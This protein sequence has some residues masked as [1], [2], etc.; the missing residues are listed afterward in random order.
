MWRAGKRLLDGGGERG[1]TWHSVMFTKI[2]TLLHTVCSAS[3]YSF[4]INTLHAGRVWSILKKQLRHQILSSDYKMQPLGKTKLHSC[5][6]FVSRRVFVAPNINI[7]QMWIT[8]WF[9]LLKINQKVKRFL[10]RLLI[11]SVNQLYNVYLPYLLPKKW[12]TVTS[13][14]KI[15]VAVTLPNALAVQERKLQL[16]GSLSLKS[17]MIL[18]LLILFF[19][20]EQ[21]M[22]VQRGSRCIALFF[23]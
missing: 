6:F 10:N 14:W 9:Y 21:A 5:N 1:V 15:F 23:L 20:L 12:T 3:L 19:S 11:S 18:I 8:V 17:W 16:P 22:R 4:I 13:I 2:L 7:S